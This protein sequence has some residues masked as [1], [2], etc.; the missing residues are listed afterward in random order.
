MAIHQYMPPVFSMRKTVR[1][2]SA[3][4]RPALLR[5]APQ[6][7]V[8]NKWVHC[9]LTNTSTTNQA[10]SLTCPLEYHMVIRLFS[11]YTDLGF[12]LASAPAM[13]LPEAWV[14]MVETDSWDTT[15]VVI[16]PWLD[17]SRFAWHFWCQ[18]LDT[19]LLAC[20]TLLMS[21]AWHFTSGLF[22]LWNSVFGVLC[23]RARM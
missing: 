12:V 21:V 4:L 13:M 20:L 16:F 5:E 23:C 14:Q 17:T 6:A 15:T 7:V 22:D 18:L 19:W 10:L 11:V 3:A 9:S 1:M 8:R 2:L